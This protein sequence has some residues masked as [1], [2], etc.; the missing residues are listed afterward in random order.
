MLKYFMQTVMGKGSS[1]IKNNFIGQTDQLNFMAQTG[2]PQPNMS[3]TFMGRSRPDDDVCRHTPK[4]A[5]PDTE[6]G[7]REVSI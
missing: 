1:I 2:S 4:S 7:K 5:D 3:T 6:T